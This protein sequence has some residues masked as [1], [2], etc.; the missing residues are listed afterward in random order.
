MKLPTVLTQALQLVAMRSIL[1]MPMKIPNHPKDWNVFGSDDNSSWTPLSVVKNQT[2]WDEWEGRIFSFSED[3]TFRHYKFSFLN[4]VSSL[5]YLSIGEIELFAPPVLVP[6]IF[7]NSI[8]LMGESIDLPFRINQSVESSGLSA[9]FW[10]KPDFSSFA[11]DQRAWIL[12]SNNSGEDW[13]LGL[14]NAYPVLRSGIGIFTGSQRLF[15]GDWSHL[16][17][18]FDPST[19]RSSFYLNGVI[20]PINSLGFDQSSSLLRLG[21]DTERNHAYF[22]LMDDVRL[23]K[24]ALTKD[25]VSLIYGHGLGDLGPRATLSTETP[26]YGEQIFAALTF[27]QP[28]VG[29]D[30][31]TGL[32]LNGLSLDHSSSEDN[33]TFNLYFSPQSYSVGSL[34]IELNQ[35][36]VSDIHG[37][38]N[39]SINQSIDFRPTATAASDL[40]VWWK[41]D[42]NISDAS[43]NNYHGTL[44]NADWNNSGKFNAAISVDSDGADQVSLS[45]LADTLPGSTISLWV[46]LK[47]E[48]FHLFQ[49]GEIN[50][51]AY[52]RIEKRRPV[53]WF[54]HLDQHYLAGVSSD[55]IHS[56]D[57]LDHNTWSHLALTYNLKD[58]LVRVFINGD[59]DVESGFSG[60]MELPTSSPLQIGPSEGVTDNLGQLDDFRLYHRALSMDEIKRIYGN[61][62]GDFDEH[63]VE[64]IPPNSVSLPLLLKA[65]FLKNGFPV[66]VNSSFT[67]Q[68]LSLTG[69]ATLGDITAPVSGGI[70]C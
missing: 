4:S 55:E 65:R 30:P 36:S 23:W 31:E 24:R 37:T 57:Y 67:A 70:Q 29:F 7:T 8:Q 3:V 58:R 61:G 41:L 60:N 40:L 42:R 26:F 68:D 33:R 51:A 20:S 14:N 63:T 6:G 39:P 44:S 18:T 5:E 52:F 1:K 9:S 59:L 27:N 48:N 49:L 69:D 64:L 66:D 50:P 13:S 34:N 2:H 62:Y 35:G 25:E 10:V 56:R 53:F 32:S 43:G 11:P 16:V 19:L 17:V 15:S 38:E 47:S 22:G 46:Y 28:V 54:D 21:T 12:S 45:G